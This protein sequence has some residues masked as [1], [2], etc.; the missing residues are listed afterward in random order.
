VSASLASFQSFMRRADA[1]GLI[2]DPAD[3]AAWHALRAQLRADRG[4]DADDDGDGGDGDGGDDSSGGAAARAA[5][6]RSAG[7][8]AAGGRPTYQDLCTARERKIAQCVQCGARPPTTNDGRRAMSP[9]PR[10]CRRAH[11]KGC[12][13][14]LAPRAKEEE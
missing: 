6:V 13:L 3:L 14:L 10:S 5:A 4:D 12:T 1:L 11:P 7:G 8:A 2:F 9:A